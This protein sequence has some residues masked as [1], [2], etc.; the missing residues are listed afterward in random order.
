LKTVKAGFSIIDHVSGGAI[1]EKLEMIGRICYKSEEKTTATSA[2]PFVTG[3]I[4]RGHEA[5][6]EHVSL[7]VQFTTDRGVTHELVRHRLASF[8]QESTRYCN[9]SADKFENSVTIISPGYWEAAS[10]DTEYDAH[11][12]RM[13]RSI[14]QD[15]AH[16]VEKAYFDLLALGNSPQQARIVLMTGT[17]AELVITANLREWRHIMNLRAVGTTGAPHP[18]MIEV[19]RPLLDTFHDFV[20]VIF[21]DINY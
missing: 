3:L 15:T 9:Y 14:Y 8:A 21:D 11:I 4:K 1:L 17:K 12:K 10:D 19:M 13:S 7:S 5:M 16:T 6:L 2:A 18:Q 20:P